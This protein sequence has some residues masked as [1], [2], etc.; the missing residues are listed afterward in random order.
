MPSDS[1]YLSLEELLRQA[2]EAASAGDRA[3]AEELY[4]QV[5]DRSPGNVEG[6]LGLAS[7]VDD[8]AEREACYRRALEVDP[9]NAAAAAGLGAA[10]AL[11]LA[12]ARQPLECAFHPGV[13]TT[14]RCSQCGRPICARCARPFPVGQL[15]PL[16][17]R[18][19]RPEP[20][21][22][23]PVQL[24]AAGGAALGTGALAGLLAAFIVG[25]GV[26]I[27]LLAGPLA[28]SALAQVALAAGS[29]KRG[30]AVQVVVGLG[31]VVGC[32]IGGMLVLQLGVIGHLPFLLFAGLMVASAV[33]WL[34]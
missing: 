33:A 4:R 14:L 15:C 5:V 34:R 22:P 31:G 6:W 13:P 1:R 28:G 24:L 9:G 17:V 32:L 12:E 8:A 3:R 11:S 23:S 19:R 30:P 2:R 10:D 16:C 29:R 18:E 27:S 7:V 26:I 21:R 25:W 20:Y